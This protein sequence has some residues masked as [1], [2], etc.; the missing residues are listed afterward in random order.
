MYR[1]FSPHR[2]DFLRDNT[3][4]QRLSYNMRVENS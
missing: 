2:T 1:A 4:E 3:V